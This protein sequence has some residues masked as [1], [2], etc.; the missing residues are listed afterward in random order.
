MHGA[1][2]RIECFPRVPFFVTDEKDL[3]LC[4][5]A[6]YASGKASRPCNLCDLCFSNNADITQIGAQRSLSHWKE[7]RN[8]VVVVLLSRTRHICQLFTQQ[9]SNGV[10]KI[11]KKVS[12]D[13]SVH[14]EWNPLLDLPGFDPCKNP[15]CRMHACDHG[16]FKRILDLVVGVVGKQ[17]AEVKRDFDDRHDR[18]FMLLGSSFFVSSMHDTNVAIIDNHAHSACPIQTIVPIICLA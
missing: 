8:T 9:N 2:R 13:W 16:T 7:V 3:S 6:L 4:V 17:K 5:T 11:P 14:P 1:G 10:R 18:S 15:S 12:K